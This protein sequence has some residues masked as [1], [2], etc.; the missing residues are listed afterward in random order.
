MVWTPQ[1]V[2]ARSQGT[3][4]RQRDSE[5]RKCV[6][7]LGGDRAPSEVLKA[8]IDRHRDTFGVEPTCMSCGLPRRAIDAM[9]RSFVIRR[10]AVLARYA[11]NVCGPR[12]SVSGR[13]TGRSTARIKWIQRASGG[14]RI[15]PS[16]GSKGD[17]YDNALAE[18]INGLYKVELIHR[19]VPWKTKEAVEFA[20]LE[21][22]S[23]FTTIDCWKPSDTCLPPKLRQTTTGNS[24]IKLSP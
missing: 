14:S 21:W 13:P 12:S 9:L 8:F 6:F 10:G 4:P 19:R 16:V 7:R 24:P 2:R 5:A 22:V 23:W 20:T 11:M 3:A 15:E 17:R 18:T 1:G